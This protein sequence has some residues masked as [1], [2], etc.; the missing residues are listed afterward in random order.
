[1]AEYAAGF[2]LDIK[3]SDLTNEKMEGT[4]RK[5]ERGK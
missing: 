5:R 2:A 4:F 3:C 1:M